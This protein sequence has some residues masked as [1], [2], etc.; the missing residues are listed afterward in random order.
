MW[1][2]WR[3]HTLPYHLHSLQTKDRVIRGDDILGNGVLGDDNVQP[4]ICKDEKKGI[5]DDDKS[6]IISEDDIM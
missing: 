4:I 6:F 2:G 3:Q 5:G 1:S